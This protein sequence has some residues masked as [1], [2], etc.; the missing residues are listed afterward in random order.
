MHIMW[1]PWSSL[2]VQVGS[3]HATPTYRHVSKHHFG[4]GKPLPEL[5][6]QASQLGPSFV[7]HCE[8]EHDAW[9]NTHAKAELVSSDLP[10][11]MFPVF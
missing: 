6:P 7:T 1:P 9:C 4:R 11:K 8:H 5:V 2:G 3:L 10:S